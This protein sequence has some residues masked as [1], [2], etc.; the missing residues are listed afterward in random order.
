M[1]IYCEQCFL[2]LNSHKSVCPAAQHW[3]RSGRCLAEV[4]PITQGY[5]N[6]RML[7]AFNLRPHAEMDSVNNSHHYAVLEMRGILNLRVR[8][9]HT[10]SISYDDC[11]YTNWATGAGQ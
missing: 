1:D 4:N 3:H 9:K 10:R 6:C 7:S 11:L 5:A 2:L 8:C